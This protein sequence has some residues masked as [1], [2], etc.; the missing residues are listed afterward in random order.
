MKFDLTS[1]MDGGIAMFKQFP[2]LSSVGMGAIAGGIILLVC[3]FSITK[4]DIPISFTMRQTGFFVDRI[5]D[6]TL[7]NDSLAFVFGP[8]IVANRSK[9]DRVILDFTLLVSGTDGTHLKILSGIR[10]WMGRIYG[11]R[12]AETL[13]RNGLEVP[14]YL[15]SPIEI[16]PQKSVQG[17]LAFIKGPH[18]EAAMTEFLKNQFSHEYEYTLVIS[19]RISATSVKLKMPWEYPTH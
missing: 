13:R 5:G 19:D 6:G 9:S 14:I 7:E 8:V 3:L 2:L 10:D 12:A 18:G 4:S 15:I 16:D 11:Q 1:I 17:K